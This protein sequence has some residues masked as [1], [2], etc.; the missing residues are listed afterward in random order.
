MRP[1]IMSGVL[2]GKEHRNA[3]TTVGR[4]LQSLVNENELT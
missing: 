3:N 1:C 2:N 4:V